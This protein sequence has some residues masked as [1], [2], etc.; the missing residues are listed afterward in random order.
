M[1][2]TG[3]N[4]E[5]LSTRSTEWTRAPGDHSE[6]L[7]L[8]ERASEQ[9]TLQSM[10]AELCGGRGAVVTLGGKPGHGQNALL[11]WAARLAHETGLR[12][13]RAQA[14]PA[15][16]ELPYGAILQ[17]MTALYGSAPAGG[18]AALDGPAPGDEAAPPDADAPPGGRTPE[19]GCAPPGAESPP[20]GPT[21]QG[22]ETPPG[23]H[24]SAGPRPAPGL[25]GLLRAARTVP[26]LVVVEDTQWLDRA[27]LNWLETLVRRLT[28]DTPLA[29]MAS[30]SGLAVRG[31]DWLH[32]LPP[33]RVPAKNLVVHGLSEGGVA[34]A[35]K[36][37]CGT[38]GDPRFTRAA[39]IGTAGNPVV[40][41]EVLRRFSSHGHEPVATRLAELR[42][43]TGA[44]A[45]DLIARTLSGLPAELTTFLGVL[46]VCGD[47]LPFSL[48]PTLAGLEPDSGR[49]LR[50]TLESTGLVSSVGMKVLLC[51]MVKA[52]LLEDLPPGERASLRSRAAEL[53]HR[54]SV[55]DDDLT[56]LL[57]MA[58]P[59]GLPWVVPAL[60]RGFAAALRADHPE[61]AAACLTRALREPLEADER[62]RL[63]LELA[64]VE[65]V[66]RPEAADRRLGELVRAGGL[67]AGLTARA[68]DLALARGNS[69]GVRREAAAALH[70][71]GDDER[72]DLIAL[73]WLADEARDES[74]PMVPEVPPLRDRPVQPAQAAVR[75][76]W[77]AARGEDPETVRELARAAVARSGPGA[78][79]VLPRLAACK[80]LILTDEWAEAG[81]ELD[82]LLTAAR[83]DHLRAATARVLTVRAGLHLNAGRLDAAARDAEAAERALPTSSLHP[84]VAP[85]L[86]SLRIVIALESG[87]RQ[88]ARSLAELP[89]PAG[90][91]DGVAW[92][93]L[94]L[95]R[96]RLAAADERWTEV[97]ELSRE[98]GRLLLRR[99][100][101]N[102]AL[103][104][105]R[106]SAAEACQ[107]LG[108]HEEATRLSF[109]EL[110]AARRWGT[111]SALGLAELWAGPLTDT[112]AG[113]MAG[114]R[115]AVL[116]LRDSPA[117]L[118]HLWALARLAGA[119]LD[120]GDRQ[121]AA[122]T[123]AELSAFT[124]AHPSSRLAMS[125]SRF[126]ERLEK[127][128]RPSQP[129]PPRGWTTL[130]T[131]E[132]RTATLAGRGHGNREI[133]ELLSVSRRTVELRL[134]NTYRKLRITGREE[135]CELVTTMEGR[136]ADAS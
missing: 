114:A 3:R 47:L 27:S 12:V 31:H 49:D 103:L 21:P 116:L 73:F 43:I 36:L 85:E 11:G 44:V 117:R 50:A 77:L 126:V 15:E 119:E 110:A 62:A 20:G 115:S 86:V 109:S 135:L 55:E 74:E 104:P 61:H 72:E 113:P 89:L 46:A 56:R 131:A 101:H 58:P 108:D 79:Q 5:C 122:R 134:S 107:F 65:A 84:L 52:R 95:A 7:P 88:R 41:Y 82:A 19:N 26:T 112:G 53:A 67:P 99:G 22:P 32:N 69:D 100:W 18:L 127:P 94:L 136:P 124:A 35:V 70:G 64:A 48:V 66:S 34:A 90:A 91:E 92:S 132:Q 129:A 40:L 10:L 121:A 80:A 37:V 45:G 57:L 128:V 28:P 133:A 42:S 81:I 13:L 9:K 125:L 17:L 38:S 63:T 105:W 130:T 60:R 68:A 14:T 33:A 51:P 29:L 71:V 111:A 59:L 23:G 118:A 98:S 78:A 96:A 8:L 4:D 120:E 123:A 30:G 25:D 54:A 102:P 106:A 97:L 76:W 83:R 93:G 1:R 2:G 24:P 75:A 87:H 6:E 39:R 16:R